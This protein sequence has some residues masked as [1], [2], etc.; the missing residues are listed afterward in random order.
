MS[1]EAKVCRAFLDVA[2]VSKTQIINAIL[3]TKDSNNLTTAQIEAIVEA[4]SSAHD[5]STNVG[6]GVIQ[7][8]VSTH[9]LAANDEKEVEGKKKLKTSKS[10][11]A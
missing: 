4:V 5:N 2:E 7:K 8:I 1:H 9:V 11:A 10:E 6:L 3:L